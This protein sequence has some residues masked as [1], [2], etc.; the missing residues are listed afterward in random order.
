MDNNKIAQIFEEIANIL[1]IQDA[2]F[3]RVNAY[4]KAALTIANSP[5]DLRSVVKK[6]YHDLENIPGIGKALEQ[7]IIELVNTGKCEEH[8][9][10]K[11]TIPEGLLDLLDIRG[12]GPKKVKLLHISLGVNNLEDLKKVAEAGEISKLP[13]MGQKSETEILKGIEEYKTFSRERVPQAEALAEAVRYIEY[14]KEMPLVTKIQYAGSLRRREDT[15]GDIDILVTI[16]DVSRSMEVM[17]FF[18]KYDEVRQV[19]AEGET[20]SSVVLQSGIDVDLRVVEE[21]SFG[22][23]LHYFTGSKAHNVKV[24]DIAKK[25]GLKVSE[26]GV[27]KGEEW[28]AG[29]SEE[30]LFAKLGLPFV[31]PELRKD[32]GEIEYGMKHGKFPDFIERKDIRGDVHTHS[33]YSDGKR[34]I[35]EMAEAF[36][37]LGYDY[38]AVTDHSPAMAVTGGLTREKIKAQWKEIDELQKKLGGKFRILKGAEVDILRDGE[39]DFEDDIL[40]ELD[41]VVVSAHLHNRLEEEEQTRRLIKAIENPYSM[42]LG[43]PTGRL[44]NKR[45]P[46]EFNMEKIIE[47]CVQNKV[48][49]EINS[50]PMRLDL[51]DKY[52]R[53]AKEKGAKFVINTDSHDSDQPAFIDFGIGVARRGWLTKDDVLNTMSFGE[54]DSYF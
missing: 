38:F 40:R 52:V 26:Y 27:F 33:T 32:D 13:G 53:I 14:M 10:L 22:A 8:E 36:M 1:E 39:L 3:F 50:S 11:K 42:I 19:V 5:L 16:K 7:K 34:S 6:N 46:M 9:R 2:G 15:I 37:A 44:V 18:V 28:I 17:E 31:I 30:E 41:V 25:M 4:K 29:T 45:A 48:A 43:H 47:A 23:A 49:L 51:Q 20:K 35:E 24:R 12:L 54:F 21:K